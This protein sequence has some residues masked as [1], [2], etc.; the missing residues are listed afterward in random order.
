MLFRGVIVRAG[1]VLSSCGLPLGCQ[2]PRP[3]SVAR[4][5]H[6]TS[7]SVARETSTVATQSGTVIRTAAH[8]AATASLSQAPE[9]LP[10]PHDSFSENGELQIEA[11]VADVLARNPSI[12]AMVSAWQAAA[13][14]YPQAVS[15]EDPMFGFMVGPSAVG[16]ESGS[17]GYML[18]ASQK[19]PWHGKRYLRG[20]GAL[21]EAAAA[22]ADVEETRLRLVAATKSAV[23]DYYLVHRLTELNRENSRI[24]QEFRD[25]ARVK[26]ETN[27][28]TQ[29]DVLQADVEL[30][31]LER[32][33][34]ELQRMERVAI[35]RINTLLHREPDYPLPSPPARLN[36]VDDAPP[37]EYLRELALARRPELAADAARIRGE[38]ASLAL[39]RTEYYPDLE[40]VGRYDG[41]WESADLRPQVGMNVN[42]PVYHAKRDAATREAAHRLNQRRAEYEQ[43]VDD[44]NNDVQAA[45]EQV[46]ESIRSL[47]LY[48][49][50]ILPAARQNVDTARTTYTTAKLDFLRLVESQRRYIM[51]QEKHREAEAELLRRLAS[52]EQAIGGPLEMPT[53]PEAVQPM[54]DESSQAR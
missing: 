6:A 30:A 5:S 52:L 15:L 34:L 16:H 32:R 45:F 9:P 12:Q 41:F 2:S 39:A 44:I 17:E 13:A 40:V 25:A 10:V 49:M 11:L 46:I 38:Q 26:Y 33:T 27:Q 1:L 54:P 22:R 53:L 21:A 35:A 31:E 24:M 50:K 48:E 47:E 29:E 4:L 43:R 19:I 42:V 18:D 20:R 37:V 28:V 7:P 36:L 51:L 23:A 8:S 3:Q 14:R